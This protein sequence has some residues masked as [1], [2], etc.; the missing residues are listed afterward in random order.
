MEADKELEAAKV[1]QEYCAERK[2]YDCKFYI[3]LPAGCYECAL[4]FHPPLGW[5]LEDID[6]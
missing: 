3:F 6:K 2:C 1:I 5:R 4:I